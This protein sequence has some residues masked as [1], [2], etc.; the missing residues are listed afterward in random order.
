MIGETISHFRVV[1]KLGAGAMGVVYAAEDLQLG[2]SVALKFLSGDLAGEEKAL[3]RFRREARAASVLNHPNICTLYGLE[4]HEGK[5]FMILEMLEGD[6]LANCLAAG[7]KEDP[8]GLALQVASALEAAHAKGIVHRDIKPSNI[9]ITTSG[10]AKV[11]DFGVAKTLTHNSAS[12]TIGANLTKS[13]MVVGSLKYMSPEQARGEEVDGRSDIYSFGL[14]L[15]EISTQASPL[16]KIAARCMEWD[17][18]L[19]YQTASDLRADLERLKRDVSGTET[20]TGTRTRR[21]ARPRPSKRDPESLAVLPFVNTGGDPDVEYLSEGIT[22]TLINNIAQLRKIRVVPRSL[23]FRFKGAEIDPQSA[24]REFN[25]DVVLSGRVTLRGETLVVGTELLD[26]AQSSQIGGAMYNRKLDDIFTIQEEIAKQIFDKLKMQLSGDEKKRV[27][28]RPTENKE[29]YQLY[30]RGVYFLNRWSPEDLRRSVDYCMQAVAVDPGYAPAYA[31]LAMAYC[32]L[33]VYVFAPA[34]EVF[35]KGKAAALRAM[36][37][38][39][40]LPEAHGALA[41]ARLFYDWDWAGGEEA[42]RRALDLNDDYA[43]GHQVMAVCKLVNG[44]MDDALVEERRALELDPVSPAMNLVM[45]LNLFFARRWDEAAEQLRHAVEISPSPRAMIL[46]AWSLA[47][48]GRAEALAV[49]G[50]LNAMSRGARMR[51]IE[52]YTLAVLGKSAEARA[53]F[54]EVMKAPPSDHHSVYNLAGLAAMVGQNDAAF[55]LLE[56]VYEERFA[57]MLYL[58]VFP[59]FERLHGDPRFTD[60]A[61]RVGLP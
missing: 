56:K 12:T 60:L 61:W 2:R 43:V 57:Q 48:A 30:L 36:E 26:V 35:P 13:G 52:G 19:R 42:C 16:Q 51:I 53:I 5:P 27:N 29:A 1:R 4:E 38:D 46:Q 39:Q 54:D 32:M 33:G 28:K 21:A 41:T 44:K 7:S 8:L 31:I 22:D 9:F 40:S 50:K 18:N 17:R 10:T 11:L 45:G 14:V 25:V 34:N 15:A 23:A 49:Q 55:A 3:A 59:I 58:K 47:H 6:T 37:L 20:G 24:G